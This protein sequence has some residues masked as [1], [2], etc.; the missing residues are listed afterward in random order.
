MPV[1][2]ANGRVRPGYALVNGKPE[3]VK[4]YLYQIRYYD[5]RKLKYESAGRNAG[6]AETQRRRIELQSTVRADAIKV[7]LKVE[8]EQDRR[9]LRETAAAY[10]RDAEQRGALEAAAQARLVTAEFMRMAGK[11]TYLDE[12]SRED[13]FK[14][15]AELRKRG[16]SDRTVANKHRRLTSWLRFAGID[17]SLLPP[18]PKYEVTLPTIYSSDEIST[19]LAEAGPSIRMAVLLALKCGLRDQELMHLE[20]SDLN[21]ADRTLIVRSKPKWRF[22][23]K[24]HEQRHVPIPFDLMHEL[25]NWKRLHTN[26]TLVL[27]TKNGRPNTKLLLA[28]KALARR[29]KLNCGQCVGCRSK[30]REC[31]Q[32][33]LHKF[34]RTYLTK[35]LRSGVDLRTVQ[36]YAGHKDIQSTMRYLTPASAKEAHAKLDAI[37][38]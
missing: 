33:T 31:M 34:R 9:T 22:K 29:A 4:D 17:R 6:D 7:G 23:V 1:K 35:L 30:R 8:G 16:C 21:L 26:Q 12:V 5:K 36:A 27:P 3:Q 24:T 11:K 38:W 10:I 18:V 2:G 25:E 15:H 13:L 37:E 19:L 14:F 20:F 28:L 32:F